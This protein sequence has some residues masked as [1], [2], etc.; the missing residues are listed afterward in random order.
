[1]LV[2]KGHSTT[3]GQFVGPLEWNSKQFAY[4]D[5]E[6]NLKRADY[7]GWMVV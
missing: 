5:R 4:E 1:V 7:D 3:T 2:L 6:G